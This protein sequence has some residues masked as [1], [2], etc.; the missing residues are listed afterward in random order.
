MTRRL[1]AAVLTTGLIGLVLLSLRQQRIAL[2]HDMSMLHV[3]MS[4][5]ETSLWRA[6][7]E[8]AEMIQPASLG[9][10]DDHDL[11][12]ALAQPADPPPDAA[13]D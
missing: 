5:D 12:S 11:R 3:R 10:P 4:N 2:V 9:V 8:V 6:R 1:I 13:H 7:A